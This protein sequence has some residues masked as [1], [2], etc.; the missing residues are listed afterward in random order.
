MID[1][2]NIAKVIG[3]LLAFMIWFYY[4]FHLNA[5][6]DDTKAFFIKQE[7]PK[8]YDFSIVSCQDYRGFNF[9]GIGRNKDTVSYKI[10]YIWDL[11]DRFQIGDRIVK[12]KG[13]KV[14]YLIN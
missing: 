11:R 3:V 7:T 6:Y 9:T 10:D 1:F 2:K 14:M 13:S 4:Q 5:T 12:R 8:E